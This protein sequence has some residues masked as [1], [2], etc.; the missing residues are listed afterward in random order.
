MH[1]KM[2]FYY[3]S[4]ACTDVGF[5]LILNLKLFII[6]KLVYNRLVVVAKT[7]IVLIN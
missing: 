4:E 6:N 3:V 7:L 2:A 5:Q 1:E